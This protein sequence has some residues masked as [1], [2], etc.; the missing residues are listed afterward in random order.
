MLLNRIWSW[1]EG[2]ALG[3]EASA[4]WFAENERNARDRFLGYRSSPPD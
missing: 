2:K 3:F 4:G 1:R